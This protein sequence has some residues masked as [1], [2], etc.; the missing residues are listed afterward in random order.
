[1]AMSNSSAASA[2]LLHDLLENFWVGWAWSQEGDGAEFGFSAE[3]RHIGGGV[4]YQ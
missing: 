2:G 1:M 4:V 3:K